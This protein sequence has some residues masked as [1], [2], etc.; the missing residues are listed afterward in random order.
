MNAMLADIQVTSKANLTLMLH[1]KSS[2]DVL[3]DLVKTNTI[4]KLLI[5]LCSPVILYDGS[6]VKYF[7]AFSLDC[8]SL[9]RHDRSD[10]LRRRD[11]ETGIVYTFQAWRRYHNLHL[12][13]LAY[14]GVWHPPDKTCFYR[15]PML[16]GNPVENSLAYG[17]I[18]FVH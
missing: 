1:K 6:E 17:N 9:F 4:I 3:H 15:W 2:A 14:V 10:Q 5:H 18:L 8:N 12:F 7:L 13:S 16:D 11:I